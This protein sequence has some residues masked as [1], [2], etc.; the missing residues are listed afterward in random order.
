MGIIEGNKALEEY[1]QA[2]ENEI[3][4]AGLD[5]YYAVWN[6]IMNHLDFAER[7]EFA[8]YIRLKKIEGKLQEL[9]VEFG[10]TDKV[11]AN[12][13]E[14]LPIPD[15]L[16][17]QVFAEKKQWD[18][19]D[20]NCDSKYFEILKEASEYISNLVHGQTSETDA[21]ES[22]KKI[23]TSEKYRFLFEELV[24]RYQQIGKGTKI[25]SLTCDLNESQLEKLYYKLP[26][27]YKVDVIFD[28]L[29][30]FKATFSG[31]RLSSGL[32]L[33]VWRVKYGKEPNG[34]ALREL[35][36]AIDTKIDGQEL[37]QQPRVIDCILDENGKPIRIPS[38][39][40]PNMQRSKKLSTVIAEIKKSSDKAV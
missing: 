6:D 13:G 18:E 31:K 38:G 32:P 36:E 15:R 20:L 39:T 34:G 28:S 24:R 30:R 33:L 11:L 40:K 21:M 1:K 10:E 2:F 35:L 9:N 22:T 17:L 23:Y 5:G 4:S 19:F 26:D 3:K 37:K 14:V 12:R 8:I 7:L 25:M 27:I 16:F 29:E